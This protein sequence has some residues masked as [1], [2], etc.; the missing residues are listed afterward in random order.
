MCFLK[1]FD[2]WVLLYWCCGM[3]DCAK[4]RHDSRPHGP[5]LKDV[6]DVDIVGSEEDL[7]V[8]ASDDVE[9]G[10]QVVAWRQEKHLQKWMYEVSV[11]LIYSSY[12]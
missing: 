2:V 7:A 4:L 3:Q 5:G 12:S 8:Y 11:C 1:C 9:V 10:F 6:R